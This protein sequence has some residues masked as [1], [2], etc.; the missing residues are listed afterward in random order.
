MILILIVFYAQ[1]VLVL[2]FMV[3]VI[4]YR[5]L[6]DIPLSQ[7]AILKSESQS[8]ASMSS[9]VVNLILIMVLGQVY[10]TLAGILN[11]WGKTFSFH[12]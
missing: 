6:I 10:Q 11:D 1:V 8:I 9:A 2:I 5:I 3:G 12:L 4:M 7:N